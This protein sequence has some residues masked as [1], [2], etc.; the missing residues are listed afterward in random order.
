MSKLSAYID[1]FFAWP[2]LA[3]AVTPL[4]VT[5]SVMFPYIYGKVVF[6]R[7]AITF[8]WIL[9]AVF[10]FVAGGQTIKDRLNFSF[11][12]KPTF[13]LVL[14]FTISSL[15]STIFAE[16]SYRAFFGNVERGEGLLTNL[17]LFMFLVGILMIFRQK[18]WKAFI[19]IS[20]LVGV[21]VAVDAIGFYLTQHVRSYGSF[22]G[23]PIFVANYLLFTICV[24]LM[25]L[26]DTKE[27]VWRILSYIALPLSLLGI[28]ATQSRGVLA[29]IIAASVFLA[30]YFITSNRKLNF[31]LRGNQ[32]QTRTIGIICFGIIVILASLFLLTKNNVFWQN[33]PGFD[34]LAAI[35][36]NDIGTGVRLVHMGMSLNSVNPSIWGVQR[37]LIGWGPENYINAYYSNFNP[38][39]LKYEPE[40]HDRAHNRVLDVLVM[41]GIV[42]LFI[43][44]AL[45]AKSILN[46]FKKEAVSD[47]YLD[48][49]ESNEYL[50]SI[51]IIFFAVAYFVQ[52]LFVFDH[53]AILISIYAFF[54][55]V[56]YHRE[57]GAESMFLS[58]HNHF[59]I[60]RA[61]VIFMT[62][63][64]IT[65]FF[66]YSIIPFRQLSL[67][68]E[69]RQSQSVD[70][71][72]ENLA[73]ITQ[74]YNYVQSEIRKNFLDN[75]SGWTRIPAALPLIV[76][77][78]DLMR[79]TTI[80][81]QVNPQV[82]HSLGYFETALARVAE[83]SELLS[84]AET[85]YRRALEL[86]PG[87]QAIML[88][89]AINLIAQGR[90]DEAL[91]LAQEMLNLEPESVYAQYYYG[92]ILAPYDWKDDL[93]GFSIIERIYK[94][95]KFVELGAKD[96]SGQFQIGALRDA[97][98]SYLYLF[99]EE[100]DEN[101]FVKTLEQALLL[102]SLIEE[103]QKDLLERGVIK[104]AVLSNVEDIR[105]KLEL[106]RK[107]GWSSIS[108]L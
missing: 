18:E 25:L 34:R 82:L 39:L 62:G 1:K 21:I 2:L 8:F 14:L 85:D 70:K 45:W 78:H 94:E 49:K 84:L 68:M 24:A 63:C 9:L 31:K 19:K 71:I 104:Q 17:F 5:P 66:L 69:S 64:L 67:F 77:L 38:E 13:V 40:W 58:R 97:Y 16:N 11:I 23:N 81:E 61:L 75:A 87:R 107:N 74:P 43:F 57:R 88:D 33:I 54:G 46:G 42:G 96:I 95:N 91:T 4:I 22:I 108:Q 79:E 73:K 32:V 99:Y 86:I 100:K 10:L 90:I 106:F 98:S 59:I 44:L 93:G 35:S 29:G 28:G 30:V 53:V 101:A 15:L 12:K 6:M 102:E 47:N 3:L 37:S 76:Q 7:F 55:F 26:S 92:A 41:Q 51:G 72:I 60:F 50:V 83:S 105:N 80:R 65:F 48:K 89:L 103:N 27:K 20:L 36:G 56:I 52:N